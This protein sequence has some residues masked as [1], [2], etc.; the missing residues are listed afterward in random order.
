VK[1]LITGV[2]VVLAAMTLLGWY[3]HGHQRDAG[4][5]LRHVH[6]VEAQLVLVRDS[7]K[8]QVAKYAAD[9]AKA[10][11]RVVDARHSTDSA[12]VH[13]RAMRE[14]LAQFIPD[15]LLDTF[16]RGVAT[17]ESKLTTERLHEDNAVAVE[18][19]ARGV[20]LNLA[21]INDELVVAKDVEIA[22]L[23]EH[24]PWYVR[25]ARTVIRGGL[26]AGGAAVGS[27]AGGPPGA[28]IGAI[29]GVAVPIK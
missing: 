24:R 8:F 23:T 6:A 19:N 10:F 9:S 13:L 7:L 29:V 5:T 27:M 12:V 1:M 22:V 14:P 17:L 20:A 26:V 21:T 18:H 25:L 16:M 15:T 28:A 11:G 4:A 2:L 3:Q